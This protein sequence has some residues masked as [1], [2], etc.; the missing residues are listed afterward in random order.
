MTKDLCMRESFSSMRS[1]EGD[2]SPEQNLPL[3]R[4][5]HIIKEL[6]KFRK[7]SEPDF[8]VEHDD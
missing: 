4:G 3:R 8:S 7:P 1:Y 2:A 5:T 6:P